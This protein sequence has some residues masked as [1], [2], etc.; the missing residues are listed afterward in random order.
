VIK[1]SL[2]YWRSSVAVVMPVMALIMS[3]PVVFADNI[4]PGVLAI[5]AKLGGRTYGQ[6][7]ENWWQWAYSV[8]T[9]TFD[10]CPNQSGRMWFLTGAVRLITGAQTL[11][12]S[13]PTAT[14]PRNCTVPAGYYVP[15]LQF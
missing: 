9:P 8:T 3:A 12:G 1:V 11:A 7:S 6:W 10:D 14:T 13:Q 5:D 15:G 4:N 2:K